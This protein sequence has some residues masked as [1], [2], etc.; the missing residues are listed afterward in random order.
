[1]KVSNDPDARTTLIKIKETNPDGVV[2][3][4]WP[5]DCNLIYKQMTELDFIPQLYL[6][7]GLPLPANPASLKDLDKDVILKNAFA[8]DPNLNPDEPTP[9]LAKFKADLVKYIG[10]EPEHLVD[11]AVAYDNIQEIVHAARKC[12]ELTN[13][14][15]REQLEQ[16]D[17]TGVAGRVQF[18]GKHY[19]DRGSRIVQYQNGKWVEV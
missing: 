6:P 16:L 18:N 14:C 5:P 17:F 1:M 9:E 12:K 3:M 11:A 13:V 15:L 2:L 7:V 4:C 8:G 10:K 19:A